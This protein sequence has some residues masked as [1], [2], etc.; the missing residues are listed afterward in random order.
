M[1]E[2][3]TAQTANTL[4]HSN[5]RSATPQTTA[6]AAGTINPKNMGSFTGAEPTTANEVLGVEREY[7]K[8]NSWNARAETSSHTW[9]L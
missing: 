2:K 5:G 8:I 6:H 4:S 3:T 1:H 9:G 7:E